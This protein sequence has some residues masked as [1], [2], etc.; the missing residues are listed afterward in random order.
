MDLL[1]LA[2]KIS[3]QLCKAETHPTYDC[4]FPKT[5]GWLGPQND[6]ATKHTEKVQKL[7]AKGKLPPKRSGK[8]APQKGSASAG[9]GKKKA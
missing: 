4:P 1:K 6:G 5:E 7:V 3:C 9:K 2:G 8:P